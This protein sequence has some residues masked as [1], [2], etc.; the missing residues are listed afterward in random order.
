MFNI[1]TQWATQTITPATKTIH[2]TTTIVYSYY[3]CFYLNCQR[4]T[5]TTNIIIT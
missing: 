3:N 2:T 1:L 4:T 5:S